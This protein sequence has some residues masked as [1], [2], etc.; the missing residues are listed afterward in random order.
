MSYCIFAGCHGDKPDELLFSSSEH[1]SFTE[2]NSTRIKELRN[3]W[4]TVSK[5][6]PNKD[7]ESQAN[8]YMKQL[9]DLTG[10]TLSHVDVICKILQF[11]D[12]SHN[13]PL[14]ALIWDG[15]DD[16]CK[17]TVQIDNLSFVPE[18]GV[19]HCLNIW[20]ES[21]QHFPKE[22]ALDSWISFK[23]LRTGVYN[24][25]IELNTTKQTKFI[26]LP[27]SAPEIQ[28]KLEIIRA[29]DSAIFPS[30]FSLENS[31]NSDTNLK[32]STV[33]CSLR[34]EEEKVYKSALS[35]TLHEH[36]P[37]T[38]LKDVQ[39][40]KNP[41]HK[42]RAS[43]KVV[44]HWPENITEFTRPYC[45]TCKKS[46]PKDLKNSNELVCNLC[47]T[48]NCKWV[49][50]FCLKVNDETGSLVLIVFNDAQFFQGVPPTDLEN[51][52]VS[53]D[54]IKAKVDSLLHS[55]QRFTCCIKSYIQNQERKYQIFDTTVL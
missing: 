30:S 13:N 45:F 39:Q 43:V 18:F 6:L 38:T 50:F 46:L 22:K 32:T 35:V 24:G 2:S 52:N 21:L 16:I 3:W 4:R 29:L 44:N 40:F 11:R 55:G 42:F 1:P 23:F 53:R 10:E 9:I 49:Y 34:G 12:I 27:E 20:P 19:I 36:I 8:P 33:G 25:N 17:S 47:N 48:G 31:N 41:V 5:K 28:K 37:L 54:T 51:S 15:T 14:K 26:L 7:E